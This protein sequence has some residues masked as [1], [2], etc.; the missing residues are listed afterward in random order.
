MKPQSS[1]RICSHSPH[2]YIDH[3]EIQYNVMYFFAY[4]EML[5]VNAFIIEANYI[6]CIYLVTSHE[7]I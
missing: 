7:V 4:Y 3:L 2:K 6:R 5:H 1:P